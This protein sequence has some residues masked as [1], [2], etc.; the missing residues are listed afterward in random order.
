MQSCIIVYES[1][2]EGPPADAS[3]YHIFSALAALFRDECGEDPFSHLGQGLRP[4]AASRL[5]RLQGPGSG[6]EEF[7]APDRKP[8][9]KGDLFGVRISFL[10]DG[11][12]EAILPR[13]AAGSLNAA[14]MP[15][16]PVKIL[17]PGEHPLCGK[18]SAAELKNREAPA[19]RLRFLTPT[20]FSRSGLQIA[21]P[22]PELVFQSLLNKW[23]SL[24]SPGEWEGM[25]KAFPSIRM[26]KFDI[27]SS[28]V[29][30]KKNS[31][32]RGCLGYCEYTFHHLD[33]EIRR[34]VSALAGFSFYAG[35]GYK[36]TQGMGQVLP[37]KQG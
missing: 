28:P 13:L 32:F 10:K 21:L 9:K 7:F 30:L 35:V 3:G 14:S 33:G 27:R 6:I 8:V 34:A 4:V 25:E 11:L 16:R 12:A 31:V 5:C 20:G 36:T 17:S 19:V 26:E 23:N 29:V 24:V 18:S 37:E 15:L 22:L 1:L 2:D